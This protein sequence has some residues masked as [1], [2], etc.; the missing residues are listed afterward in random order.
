MV[1]PST[2]NGSS[3]RLTAQPLAAEIV[4]IERNVDEPERMTP[5][6]LREPPCHQAPP[7]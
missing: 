7:E 3:V 4:A 2:S 1:A 6:F 5:G